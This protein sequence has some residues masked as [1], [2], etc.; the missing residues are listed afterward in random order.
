[1]KNK[2]SILVIM[3]FLM[4]III[5]VPTYAAPVPDGFVGV[6]W[7]STRMQVKQIM[8]E[9]GWLRL[10]DAPLTK[11]VFKGAFN[12]MPGQ[13]SFVLAGESFVEGRAD[14]LADAPERSIVYT[15]MKYEETVK[16]LSEKYGMP[17]ES[18]N[19]TYLATSSWKIIDTG[20]TDEYSIVLLFIKEGFY[21]THNF[22]EKHVN[23]SVTYTAESLRKRLKNWNI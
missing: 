9:R 23:F 8:S 7:G 22:Q 11:E 4:L 3:V 20:T 5:S 17:I 6:P 1:M 10:T 21:S 2:V 14:F 19:D 13:L 16:S 12:G 18:D 15:T